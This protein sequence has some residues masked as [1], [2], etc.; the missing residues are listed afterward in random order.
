MP[1]WET[2]FD[3]REGS[4]KYGW[5]SPGEAS[6]EDAVLYIYMSN[7]LRAFTLSICIPKTKR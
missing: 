3:E 4:E 5:D 6:E 2:L 1:H 7:P